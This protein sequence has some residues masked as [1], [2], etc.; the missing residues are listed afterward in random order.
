MECM[1]HTSISQTDRIAEMHT[2]HCVWARRI[3]CALIIL[4][5]ITASMILTVLCI[6]S[7]I[8]TANWARG[9]FRLIPEL[10]LTL[11]PAVSLPSVIRPILGGA[12]CA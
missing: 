3:A 2:K 12:S 5:G 10:A 8:M 4:T 1:T 7:Y 9:M 6:R 11:L